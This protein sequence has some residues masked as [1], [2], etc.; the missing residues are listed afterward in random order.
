[1]PKVEVEGYGAF[2]V[3]SGK[4]LIR[5][6]ET[7][8]VDILHLCGGFARCT[9]C[10]VEF[11]SGEPDRMTVAENNKLA[12]KGWTDSVLRLSCQ[13]EVLQDMVI[14]PVMTLTESGME[15][16]GPAPQETIT[17]HPEWMIKPR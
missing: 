11:K 9:T 7:N 4:R 14:D 16:A 10:R 13:I 6:L 12:E 8:G 2:E 17:P 5:A 1:M 3:E 15:D